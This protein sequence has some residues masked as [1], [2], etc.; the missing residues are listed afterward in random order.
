MANFG[1]K[2]VD[3]YGFNSNSVNRSIEFGSAQDLNNVQIGNYWCIKGP[4]QKIGIKSRFSHGGIHVIQGLKFELAD[5]TIEAFGMEKNDKANVEELEVPKGQHIRDVILRTGW[6]IDQIGFRTN[7]NIQLGPIG[8][9]GGHERI[10]M[11]RDFMDKNPKQVYLHGIAGRTYKTKDG[12]PL[13]AKLK[14]FF[15]II[16][17]AED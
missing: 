13:I 17:N 3:T 7:E 10:V 8:G 9:N 4:F 16:P 11:P 2:I 15:V 12:I 6:Y 14:F 5:G 1:K